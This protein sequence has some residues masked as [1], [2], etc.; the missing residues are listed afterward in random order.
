MVQT[1][2]KVFDGLYAG[3]E[4]TDGNVVLFSAKGEPSVIFE[5]TNPVQQLCTDAGQY[6]RFQDVLSNVVQTLGEGYALQKQD[7]LCKQAYHHDVPEDA[8]FLTRSYFNYFEGR[9]FTEIRTYLIVTQEAQRSQ[10]VQY[11]PKTW[12]DFHT[13][14]SKVDD[15]LT[16]R[17]IRHHKLSKVEADEY[18]HRFM[19]FRFRHGAFSMTNFKASDEYLRTG[20]RIIRS[21][22]L[23]DIDEINLPSVIKPYTQTNINGYPI[24]TDLFSFLTNIPFSDCVVFNQVV[25][26]PNQ[27]KLLRKLQGKA[28]R[29]GSMP[30][31]SNKIAKAD[32]EEVLNRLAVDSSML[33]YTNFNILVSCPVDKVTPV[34]SYLET[35][36]YECGIM[37]SRTAYNQLELFTDSFPGNAYA[38]NSDYDLFL[39]LSDA[40]L[41]FFFKEHL[42]ESEQTPLTTYYTDR[43]GLPVC[44]DFT[45]KEGKIKMT[46]NANFF[47]IG[48]SG[49]GKSFHTNSV[50]RQLLEQN[51]DVVMV[52]TGDS[53]EGI[54]GYFGGTYISYTKEKPISMNP[55]KVTK[56][57]YEL[58]FGEKKNFL[59]SLIF[60]IFKGNELPTKIE[61]ML[62]NQTIV[63]YYDTYFHP[64]EKFTEKERDGLRQKLLVDA[65]MEEDYDNYKDKMEDIDELINNT[66]EPPSKVEENRMLMLPTEAHRQKL[67]RQY[68]SLNALAHDQGAT[69]AERERALC[70]MEKFKK[71]LYENSFLIKIEK[72]IDYLEVQKRR[73]RVKELSFNSYY[74][75]AL[76]RIPQI[77]SQEKISFGIRDFAAILK[78]FYRGGELET[79]LNS[80]LNVN[81]FDERFIVFEID[82]IKDDPVLFPIV[83]LIIM[84]V[85]LQKM[86]IKKG[87]KA[88]IIEE[89]WKAIASPTMAEYIKYLYKTVRKFHGIAGVVTQ[90]LNDVID[91]PIVK[92]AIINNSDVKVLLD[93]TKFKDRYDEIAAILGLTQ[94][95][96]QQIFTVNSLNNREN[97][98][99][100]KEV[101]IC[102][103]QNSDVYGVEEPPEC[104][105]AYTTERTEKEALKIYLSYY[106]NM[107]EAITRIEADRKQAGGDKY[108]VFARKVNQQQKV[109]SLW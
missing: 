7:I 65:K 104:Y 109:M 25:Q 51:T 77:T 32:I 59:K 88:L 13:K 93:Q 96:R 12:L 10:F 35:K 5:M 73:L 1:K 23:V 90:E 87:R 103:G 14:V 11:D 39:T 58:N 71:E 64:F 45:G 29:H 63:E 54:C 106:G 15:I 16:E 3:L 6:I 18:C 94:I 66:E 85:F 50:V 89:A 26:I 46:D 67:I 79:T 101:W 99:Y 75:F 57:E 28:K 36:L 61:D 69:Q 21:Y 48:P 4:E 22:P 72:Q 74:E 70:I 20:N 100:F 27:R 31:P 98:N 34:T 92:E 60:L 95:Q 38:F 53:Y 56:E 102:R 37:P 91:S 9:E 30:D 107:Q 49:S 44:I 19:A 40:A 84:D 47:C 8:E 33:V 2:K 55:F 76:E 68:R 82:K 108:L 41:C 62:V 83:V 24:A 78:Q 105:W 86:R 97:R 42:K 80:D 52:D 43:Q 81:L 17:G